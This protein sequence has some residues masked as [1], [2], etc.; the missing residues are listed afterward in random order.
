[1]GGGDWVR[2]EPVRAIKGIFEYLHAYLPHTPQHQASFSEECPLTWWSRC[3]MVHPLRE[4]RAA[5]HVRP[6]MQKYTL[7]GKICKNMQK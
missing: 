4:R 3:D 7:Y 2:K 5:V 1:V 6:N